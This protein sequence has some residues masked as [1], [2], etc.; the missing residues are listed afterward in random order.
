MS[1]KGESVFKRKDGRWEARYIKFYDENDKAVY[2]YV[3][4]KSYLEAKKKRCIIMQNLSIEKNT[5]HYFKDICIQWLEYIR[6]HVKTSTYAR[7]YQ[8]IYTQII[9]KIGKLMIEDIDTATIDQYI[10]NLF[11]TGRLDHKGGLSRKTV[12]DILMI[13]KN[14]FR[15]GDDM[16]LEIICRLDRIKVKMQRKETRVLTLDEQKLLQ[17]Y[18]KKDNSLTSLGILLS[19]YTGIRIGELCALKWE[20][21]FLKEKKMRI[22][23]TLQRI[24]NCNEKEK[25]TSLILTDPKS[26]SSIRD[27]PLPGFIVQQ[28]SAFQQDSDCFL[29]SGTKQYIEPRTVQNRF[30]KIL[31]ELEIENATFHSLRH[32]FATRCIEMNFEVKSLSEILGHSNVNITLNRYVHS[33]FDLKVK[34]MEKINYL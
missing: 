4:G 15:Y 34:N 7:Y 2:G 24:S 16:G 19:M 23:K 18:L 32:T 29:L 5:K 3:Y 6:F 33:S 9:P 31:K 28:L 20:N 27:I 12:Q 14:I 11:L 21:I 8:I 30:K 10:K 25:K 26:Q 22:N 13:L 17:E 1:R